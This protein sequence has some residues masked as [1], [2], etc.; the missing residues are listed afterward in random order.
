M[1]I[2]IVTL[3]P[4]DPH[5]EV[6][7]IPRIPFF[8]NNSGRETGGMTISDKYAGDF[9]TPEQEVGNYNTSTPWESCITIGQQW[10]WRPN[11]KLKSTQ[12]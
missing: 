7:K 9:G 4:A 6:K 12:S 10:A 1:V 2:K 8:S 11:D 3:P 5:L